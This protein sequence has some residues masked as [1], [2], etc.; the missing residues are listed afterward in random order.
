[1]EFTG[2]ELVCCSGRYKDVAIIHAPTILNN[3]TTEY[4]DCS[5]VASNMM[6]SDFSEYSVVDKNSVV[7][8][9]RVG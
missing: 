8:V 2:K 9:V 1:L 4:S 6:Q 7:G 3:T 5:D